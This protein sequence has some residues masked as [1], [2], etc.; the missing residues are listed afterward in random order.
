MLASPINLGNRVDRLSLHLYQLAPCR[1]IGVGVRL[2]QILE[3]RITITR[4]ELVVGVAGK[5]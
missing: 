5:R 3:E 2:T 1:T 4:M